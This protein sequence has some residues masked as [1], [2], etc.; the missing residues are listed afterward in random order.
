MKI[1]TTLNTTHTPGPWAIANAGELNPSP[2]GIRSVGHPTGMICHLPSEHESLESNAR[3]IAAAPE[4]LEVLQS[5]KNSEALL[6]YDLWEMINEAIAKG[7]LT[8]EQVGKLRQLEM[9]YQNNE[10]ERGFKYAELSFKD[11]DSARQN[12]VAGGV[13][14]K[15]FWL[16]C[17]LLVGTLGIEALVLFRGYPEGTDPLVVGRVLGLMDAVAMLVLSYWYGTTNGSALKS[18]LLAS[19]P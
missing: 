14:G 15:L 8:P 2:C 4:M 18:E 1:T 6:A 12:N 19:K 13:Q 3:L 7:Q 11:R 9:E 5:I 10:K 17:S 16:S